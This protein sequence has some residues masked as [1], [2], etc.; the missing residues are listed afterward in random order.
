[1]LI[2]L[3][4]HNIVLIEK[5]EISFGAGL[6]IFTGETGAGKSILLDSLMLALGG[7]GDGGLVRQGFEQGTVIAV[8][9]VSLDH[10]VRE[11][12][13]AEGFEEQ[14]DIVLKRVQMSDGR[15]R[16]F[17]NDRIV[18]V[19]FLRTVG[20]HLV[21]I[22]GQHDD[23]AFMDVHMHRSM[24]DM[25]AGLGPKRAELALLYNDWSQK[26]QEYEKL[27]QE[28]AAVQSEAEYLQAAVEELQQLAPQ[29]GE[30]EE[31]AH[32]RSKMIQSEKIATDI[33][34]ANEVLSGSQ[35][36]V[37][38]LAAL[39][40]RLERKTAQAPEI[41]EP[42]VQ[43]LDQS[44]QSLNLVQEAVDEAL[45][46]LDF[47]PHLLEQVEERLFALRAKARKHQT[48]VDGLLA[49]QDKF[50]QDLLQIDNQEALLH[51]LEKD[52][53]VAQEAYDCAARE[54]TAI[55]K[56]QSLHLREAILQE[57]P[58]LKLGEADFFVKINSRDQHRTTTGVDDIEFWVQTNPGTPSGPITKVASGGE[59][60]RFLL[61]L[62]VVLADKD[63]APTLIF[64]EIDTGVGG[65][66]ADAIGRRLARL[67]DHVQVISITHAPQVAARAQEHFLI[68]KEQFS[69]KN[70][71]VTKV[72]KLID[73]EKVDEIARMFSG[74]IITQEARA[75]AKQLLAH[76]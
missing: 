25:F 53:Q 73:Q 43:I 75:A 56:E 12:L 60:S 14:G 74:H 33:E 40:R 76:E 58:D 18:T 42:I 26:K 2:Q 59:L 37:S 7:R 32:Q 52:V 10:P 71:T 49:L 11:I 5:L 8:F 38:I 17:L 69:E 36:V 19:N 9:D 30:E 45:R 57:L 34:D 44:L 70:H 27:K 28:I 21:E 48:T 50:S 23:R 4:I 20:Q 16:A 64:D 15:S 31:L 39:L 24:L 63:S 66:V 46:S 41:I 62:K 29:L 22:H 35:S 67:A 54:L 51:K 3:S 1:M 55:R 13:R 68:S 6:S 61:A 65:A 72:K 47:D